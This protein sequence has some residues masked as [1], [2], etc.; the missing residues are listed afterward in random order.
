M[1]NAPESFKETLQRS[2]RKG[3]SQNKELQELGKVPPQALDLEEAVLGALMLEKDAIS[4]VVDIL[5]SES[6][7]SDINKEI[8]TAIIN[9]FD[10]SQPIDILT[11]TNELRNQGKLDFIGGAYVVS[12]LT[13]RV[14]S[15]ANIEYHARVVS[16]KHILRELIRIS[17]EVQN[18]AY[19]DTTDVFDL[20]DKTEKKLFDITQGN[21][22][23]SYASMSTLISQAIKN[24]EELTENTDGLSG[25]PSGFTELDRTTSGWQRSDL[26]ILAARPGMGKTSFVLSL[27]RNTAIDHSRGVAIFSLEMSALQLVHRLISAEA[28]IDAQKL[29][30]GELAAHEWTQLNVKINNLSEASIFIDDTPAINIF[31]LRAKCRRLKKQH[32]IEVVIVDYLQLMNAES[33]NKGMTNREQE[34]SSISRALK[35]IA[36]ELDIPVIALSQLSRAVETR[37]GTKR[38]ILSDLRES[39]SIEQDADQVMFIYRPEYYEITEDEE[40]KPTQGMAEIIV[41]KNRHG[42]VTTIPVKFIN[43]F[44]K[45]DDLEKYTFSSGKGSSDNF[46][47]KESKMNEDDKSEEETPF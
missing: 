2:Q 6:F 33:E 11:V 41:A 36:K 45:F 10:N 39:G 5:N 27:A 21:L 8:Y 22:Q 14:A 40:G 12:E 19:D 30:N 47:K 38:P 17:S 28:E 42:S 9:L 3:N 43:Q 44:A 18:E 26:I 20:L 1:A 24:I 31:E 25:V 13:N 29:K 23:S 4:V 46:I 15:S 34:I 16:E 32:D 7:Y 37:G 35:G